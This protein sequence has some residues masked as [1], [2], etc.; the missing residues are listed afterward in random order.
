MKALLQPVY[1]REDKT[2]RFEKQSARLRELLGDAADF[3]PPLPLGDPLPPAD[4]VIFPEILGEAYR[5]GADF[6]ALDKPILVVTSE[7]GTFSMW[8]W[9]I[10][11]FLA[12]L[13]VRCLA[14]YNLG[15]ARGFCRML[16]A[17]R[18]LAASK[19]VVFQDNPGDGFQPEIFKSFFWW[20]KECTKR[21]Q[22]AFGLVVEHR[23]LRELGK[24]AAA[25]S[26]AEALLEWDAWDYPVSPAVTPAARA[27]AARMYLALRQEIDSP[28]IIGM[29]TNCLNESR[30]CPATPC[31]AWDRILE[32][33]GIVAACEGDTVSLATM[34][35]VHHG[36]GRPFMMTNIYPFLMGDAATKHEK[37]P[38]FPAFVDRPENHVLLAH[39]GYFGLV[40]RRFASEWLVR[41]KA[42]A[43]VPPEAHVFDAKMPTGD[44]TLTKL[45]AGVKKLMCVPAR[46]K[47]Y[48][49]YDASS[50]CRNGGVIEVT[51]GYAFMDK[52]YSHHVVLVAGDVRRELEAMGKVMGVEVETF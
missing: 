49:Q 21:L 30:S 46:L 4:G 44:V 2:D 43:I 52:I 32:E 45:D 26:D 51:D 22:D 41:E 13:G 48:V 50:D 28:D 8:D 6:Q 10:M 27:N 16:A 1:F 7:F 20:E 35:M 9:E 47:G 38:G 12:D 14:P 5:R 11:N 18:R 37:I 19:M 36:L 29:G 39:C 23:S 42:L 34:C 3:L 25:F 40:P 17:R 15:Q 31:L 33:R 24:K